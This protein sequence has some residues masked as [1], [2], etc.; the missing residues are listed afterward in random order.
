[1]HTIRPLFNGEGFGTPYMMPFDLDK[2]ASIHFR[3]HKKPFFGPSPKIHASDF[4]KRLF[5]KR[6]Y[7]R[8]QSIRAVLLR[9]WK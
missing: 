2:M 9:R 8:D 6:P 3:L 5:M 4:G 1:M 7:S